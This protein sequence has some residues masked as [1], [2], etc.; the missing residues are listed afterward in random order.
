[1]KH[2]LTRNPILDVPRA[3]N[4]KNDKRVTVG[5]PEAE[6]NANFIILS[7]ESCSAHTQKN[8]S[9]GH[10]EGSRRCHVTDS[11]TAR[12]GRQAKREQQLLRGS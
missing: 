10:Q 7:F 5:V 6:T 2:C 9:L 1:M 12:Y 3:R 11:T 8:L 4:C